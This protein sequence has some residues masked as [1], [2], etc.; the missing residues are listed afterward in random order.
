MFDY[1][2]PYITADKI[3]RVLHEDH[4]TGVNRIDIEN[5]LRKESD[6]NLNDANLPNKVVS[7]LK[8]MSMEGFVE[9]GNDHI[10]YSIGKGAQLHH[11]GG[12]KKK[13]ERDKNAD[14]LKFKIDN[15][16]LATNRNVRET[17]IISRR[18]MWTTIIVALISALATIETCNIARTDN[19]HKIE[20]KSNDLL[21]QQ[22]QIQLSQK[23]SILMKQEDQINSLKKIVSDSIK[24]H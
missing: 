23:D 3:L 18:G 7:A 14:E 12:Y 2:E 22:K 5:K 13:F 20:I 1:I 4:V 15:S 19:S 9:F 8:Q 16:I 6:E 21:I 17:N 11:N 10:V 24:S